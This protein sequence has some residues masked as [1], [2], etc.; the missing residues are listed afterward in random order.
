MQNSVNYIVLLYHIMQTSAISCRP[1][2]KW[3]VVD[4]R[5]S[6]RTLWLNAKVVLVT[7]TSFVLARHD[8]KP[9][10]LALETAVAII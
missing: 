6:I 1:N 3:L 5:D 2:V 9:S 8:A 7:W 4:N 10:I